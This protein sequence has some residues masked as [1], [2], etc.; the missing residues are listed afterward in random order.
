MTSL[1]GYKRRRRY[2]RSVV[3]YSKKA[4]LL[5]SGVAGIASMAKKMYNMYSGNNDKGPR[6]AITNQHD[7]MSLYRRRRAPRRVRRR[8]RKRYA[9]FLRKQ[10]RLL[11]NNTQQFNTLSPD[12]GNSAGNQEWHSLMLFPVQVGTGIATNLYQGDLLSTFTNYEN[13]GL[14]T[15]SS[16]WHITGYTYDVTINNSGSTLAEC[17]VYEWVAR[18]DF[19]FHPSLPEGMTAAYNDAILDEE[20]LPGGNSRQQLTTLGVTPFDVNNMSRYVLILKK[21]RFYIA[22]GQA[23]SFTRNVKLKSPIKITSEDFPNDSIQADEFI[24]K[25]G[26]TRGFV[27]IIK[28]TPISGSASQATEVFMN[29]QSRLVYKV[30]DPNENQNAV[31]L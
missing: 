2:G 9:Y 22:S 24:Q 3:G 27:V 20:L 11:P 25:A 16:K 12:I 23:I 19:R 28:G 30:Q 5:H 10:L 14:T 31:G 18:K 15:I 29:C 7:S 1:S 13:T 21:Q 26:L 17:D 6:G 4:K 8:A